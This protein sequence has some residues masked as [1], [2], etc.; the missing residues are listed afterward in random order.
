MGTILKTP[1]CSKM[2]PFEGIFEDSVGKDNSVGIKKQ[3]Q[4]CVQGEWMGIADQVTTM[5][6]KRDN[7]KTQAMHERPKPGKT[8]PRGGRGNI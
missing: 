6:G 3:I 5:E 7:M 1:F 8:R 2:C 4:V